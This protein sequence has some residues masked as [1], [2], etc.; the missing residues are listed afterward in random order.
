MRLCVIVGFGLG[1]W[2]SYAYILPS[3]TLNLRIVNV[4]FGDLLHILV[5]IAVPL[6]GARLGQLVSICIGR[7]A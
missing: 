4:T 5:G 2:F 7:T 6:A 3:E 1:A